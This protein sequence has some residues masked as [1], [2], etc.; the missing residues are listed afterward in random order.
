MVF[1]TTMSKERKRY[2]NVYNKRTQ[3]VYTGLIS[4]SQIKPINAKG[5]IIS[6][7]GNYL[8]TG[9]NGDI[10]G[11]LNAADLS[12]DFGGHRDGFPVLASVKEDD[13]PVIFHFKFRD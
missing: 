8:T 3:E 1:F 6:G 12:F 10:I 9:D 7:L 4:L 5:M 13:N 2:W 11:R